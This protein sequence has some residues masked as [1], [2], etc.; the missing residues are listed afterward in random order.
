[1][2]GGRERGPVGV[3]VYSGRMNGRIRLDVWCFTA[4]ST[5][6]DG[7][8]IHEDDTVVGQKKTEACNSQPRL[9]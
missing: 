2:D 9:C 1:M 5:V 4:N 3:R 8:D 7:A 6:L